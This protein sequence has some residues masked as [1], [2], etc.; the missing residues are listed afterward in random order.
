MIPRTINTVRL[1][2]RPWR[3]EDLPDLLSYATDEEWARF[4]PVPQPYEESHGRAFIAQQT[5]RDPEQHLAWAIVHDARV[6]GGFDLMFR[7]HGRV[8][9]I[10]YSIAPS[11]WNQ[12]LAT[13]AVRGVVD[14]AFSASPTLDRIC[15]YTHAENAPSGRVLEKVGMTAEGTLRQNMMNRGQLFDQRWFGVL[16]GEWEAARVP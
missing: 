3:F 10:G 14:A 1:V 5:L 6:I 11:L 8:A 12:G 4:L 2:L 7:A 16:R 15:A 9:E 13:E